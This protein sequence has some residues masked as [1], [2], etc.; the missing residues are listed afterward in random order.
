[1]ALADTVVAGAF[2][3]VGALGGALGGA[4]F[5]QHGA[6]KQQEKAWQQNLEDRRRSALRTV[7]ARFSE[8]ALTSS[9]ATSGMLERYRSDPGTAQVTGNPRL[10]VRLVGALWELQ[11]LTTRREV[12]DLAW[13][14]RWQLRMAYQAAE[15]LIRGHQAGNADPQQADE[16]D[17]LLLRIGDLRAE[18]MDAVRDEL[19]LGKIGE[20]DQSGAAG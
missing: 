17:S 7:A 20:V 19:G 3:V 2:G 13:R 16:L 14:L 15:K 8:H 9:N 10:V 5:A 12:V 11:L 6:A 4:W 1:M 18:F